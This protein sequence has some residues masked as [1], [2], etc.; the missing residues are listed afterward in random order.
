MS[1]AIYI[2]IILVVGALCLGAGYLL[3]KKK[4]VIAQLKEKKSEIIAEVLAKKDATKQDILKVLE[5]KL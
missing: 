1:H 2:F 4:K 3:G 5:E